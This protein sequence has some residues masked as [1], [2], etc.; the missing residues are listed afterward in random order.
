[1]VISGQELH[2]PHRH[3]DYYSFPFFKKI[4]KIFIFDLPPFLLCKGFTLFPK[5]IQKNFSH[6]SDPPLEKSKIP[7]YKGGYGR[8]S[9]RGVPPYTYIVGRVPNKI[10]QVP[11]S[12]VIMGYKKTPLKSEVKNYKCTYQNL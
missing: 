5:K 11:L 4:C 6:G 9:C 3:N 10:Q 1:M 8:G 7:L 2:L 12:S